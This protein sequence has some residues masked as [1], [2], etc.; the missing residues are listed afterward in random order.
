MKFRE[1]KNGDRFDFINDDKPGFN[2]YFKRCV[3]I[4]ARKYQAIEEHNTPGYGHHIGS[5]NAD[6]YHAE[7]A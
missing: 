3:K 2:S 5:I 1:L 7:A 4:S 6:V